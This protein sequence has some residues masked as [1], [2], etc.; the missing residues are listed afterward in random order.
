MSKIKIYKDYI[1]AKSQGL[2]YKQVAKKHGITRTTLYNI[3]DEVERGNDKKLTQCI[4]KSFFNCLWE[5]RYKLRFL[6]IPEGR[7]AESVEMLCSLIVDMADDGFS[8]SQ[9]AEKVGRDRATVSYHLKNNGREE[10][11]QS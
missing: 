4:D 2:T 9:I 6:T 5:H 10:L 8:I 11:G 7:E 3:V 1:T